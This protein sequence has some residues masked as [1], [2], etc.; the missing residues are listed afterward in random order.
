MI[1]IACEENQTIRKRV[2]FLF[3]VGVMLVDG[4]WPMTVDR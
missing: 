4:G 3:G 2:V 1:K